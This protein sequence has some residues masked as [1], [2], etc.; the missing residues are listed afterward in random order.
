MGN[1]YDVAIIG[2]GL[3]G[4]ALARELKKLDASIILF[5]KARGLGGRVATRRLGT[6]FINHG[7][8]HFRVE[9]LNLS[10]LV[11]LGLEKKIFKLDNK[12]CFSEGSINEWIKILAQDLNIKKESHLKKIISTEQGYELRDKEDK[13][14]AV[15]KTVILATPAPQAHDILKES[16]LEMPQLSQ[17]TYEASIQFFIQLKNQTKT[18]LNEQIFLAPKKIQQTLWYEV[19]PSK[20]N[21]FLDFDKEVL[22]DKFINELKIT[23]ED[24]LEVH[25]HKWR[26]SRAQVFLKAQ[27]Q[28][29]LKHKNVYLVG[30]YF[31][32]NDLNAA[33][34]SVQNLMTFFN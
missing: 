3:S 23:R 7:V 30:D 26:Y 18:P 31:F 2:C 5:D 17:V 20:I 29:H 22:I 14:M 11:N 25:A 19:I 27:D 32:G 10:L 1:Y 28:F 13:V 21:D 15:A 33:I 12:D 4:I 8:D 24:I 16:S 9:D 34:K 6:N